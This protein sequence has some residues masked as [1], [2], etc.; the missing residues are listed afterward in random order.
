MPT[1]ELN[2]L[3][4]A[5]VL[6][7]HIKKADIQSEIIEWLNEA[8]MELADLDLACFETTAPLTLNTGISSYPISTAIAANV[9]NLITPLY[10][11]EGTIE[12][13]EPFRAKKL[14]YNLLSDPTYNSSPGFPNVAWEYEGILYFNSTPDQNYTAY[15][16]FYQIPARIT[17]LTG[18]GSTFLIPQHKEILLINYAKDL[19]D[20]REKDWDSADRIKTDFLR[21]A[22]KWEITDKKRYGRQT[23]LIELQRQYNETYNGGM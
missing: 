9:R 7:G 23:T 22:R 11:T 14:Y 18:A 6:K 12:L 1:R 5:V 16:D 2:S 8:Y 3:I 4:D 10:S 19:L 17:A 21:K 15:V 13:V 20:A